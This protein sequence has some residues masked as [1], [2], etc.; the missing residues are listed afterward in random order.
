RADA[1]VARPS[2]AKQLRPT[3]LNDLEG[4]VAV[5]SQI[6]TKLAAI[7][8]RYKRLSQDLDNRVIRGISRSNL[9]AEIA[10]ISRQ[11]HGACRIR[12]SQ[13]FIS[14]C[15]SHRIDELIAIDV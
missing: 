15:R 4:T 12:A 14:W 5:G 13:H 1:D 9:P 11:H 8:R 7:R 10:A 2:D 3:A 6:N